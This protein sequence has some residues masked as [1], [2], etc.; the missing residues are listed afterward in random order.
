MKNKLTK[1]EQALL[2][3]IEQGGIEMIE[4]FRNELD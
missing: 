3:K 1:T 2:N 4:K